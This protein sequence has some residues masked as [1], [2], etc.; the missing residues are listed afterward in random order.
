MSATGQVH[1]AVVGLG[2]M[3][4][5]HLAIAN[6]SQRLKVVAVC[7]SFAMLGQ[8]VEKHCNIAYVP[9]YADVVTTPGLQG[10]IIA[11]PTRSHDA[12]VR[13]AL[14][15]GL[16]VFCEKPMTL[17]AAVSEELDA[18]AHARGLVGQ[19]GYH[20]RFVGTFVEV[21]RLI[22]AGAIGKIRHV[23]GEAYGPVVL[24]PVA[25]TW[26][27]E[28]SE[29]GGCLYD[30]AAHPINLMN[31]YVGAS[32]DCGGAELA[33]QYSVDVE[34]AVYANL[35][36]AGGVTGQVTVNWSDETVRKMSTQ[37][38]IWGDGGKIVVDRQELKIYIG[39]TGQAQPNYGEGWTVRYITELTA[40]V[41]YYLRGE[42]YSAQLEGFA[43]AVAAKK[44]DCVN[45]FKSAAET[46]RTLEM[47]RARA[48]LDLPEAVLAAN[49]STPPRSQSMLARVLRR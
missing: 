20:N 37:I 23:H 16:H 36:F 48:A 30:Y 43:Q 32:A 27:S 5:S 31:W 3:G 25:R 11:T 41:D 42:E 26:R 38:S 15:N 2:K 1:V 47:I 45:N 35:R 14:A 4:V 18:E 39:A 9:N 24:K 12:M 29:G 44:F 19:V 49:S 13:Q 7:D 10:V 6:A 22:D 34:D 17:S 46:D 40:N 33:K 8:M 21:K 28:S